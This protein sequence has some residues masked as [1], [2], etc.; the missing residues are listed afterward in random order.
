M[1]AMNHRTIMITVL[2][3]VIMAVPSITMIDTDPT[4]IPVNRWGFF[5]L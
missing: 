5:Y 1:C 3:T 2:V 4:K